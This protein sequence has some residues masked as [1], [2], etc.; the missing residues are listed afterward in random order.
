MEIWKSVVGFEDRYEVS[1]LGRV[2]SRDMK[3]GA[4]NGKSAIRKGRLLRTARKSNGYLQLSLR[5]SNKVR[6]E[7]FVHWIVAEAFHGPRPEGMHVC[8]NDGNRANNAAANLR[9]ATPV[10]NMA[11]KVRHGTARPKLSIQDVIDIRHC[12]GLVAC[13]TLCEVFNVTP[14]YV[15]NIQAGRSQAHIA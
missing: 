4:R 6:R 1:S 3:V 15:Y 14:G 12:K 11:D 2:R 13:S 9:Y 7:V 5:G 8:H 10:E